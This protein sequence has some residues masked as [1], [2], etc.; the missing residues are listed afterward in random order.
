MKNKKSIYFLLPVVVLIWSAI[1]YQFYQGN[2]EEVT[3][4]YRKSVPAVATMELPKKKVYSLLL[5]YPDPFLDPGNKPATPARSQPEPVPAAQALAAPEKE[6]VPAY[7]WEQIKYKG[8]VEHK[9]KGKVVALLEIRGQSYMLA[10]GAMQEEVLLQK[11]EI[12]SVL[13][14][15]GKENTYIRK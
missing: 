7:N 11:I 2:G 10:A 4:A 15:V 8:L 5:N 1:V 12:D 6:E 9:G 14:K 3:F 13:L